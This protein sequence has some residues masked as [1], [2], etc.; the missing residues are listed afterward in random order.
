MH[1]AGCELAK[2]REL[3]SEPRLPVRG[4]QL[5]PQAGRAEPHSL[6]LESKL[7]GEFFGVVCPLQQTGA[8]TVHR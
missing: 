7:L 1:E 6:Q 8:L 3:M 5:L 4:L 2:E